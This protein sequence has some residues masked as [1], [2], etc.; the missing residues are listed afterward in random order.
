MPK[1][2]KREMTKIFASLPLMCNFLNMFPNTS[3][4]F[5][6]KSNRGSGQEKSGLLLLSLRIIADKTLLVNTELHVAVHLEENSPLLDLVNCSVDTA[7]SDYLVTSLELA[8]EFFKFFLLLALRTDHE[9][10]HH[11]KHK[12]KHNPKGDSTACR[13]GLRRSLKYNSKNIHFN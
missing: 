1:A 3:S 4:I 10:P 2:N 7:R 5:L 9:E 12:C 11:D 13:S 8:A 6:K